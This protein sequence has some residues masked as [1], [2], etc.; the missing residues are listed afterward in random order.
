MRPID[1]DALKEKIDDIWNG[2]P[3][4]SLGA[5]LLAMIDSAP[6]IEPKAKVIAQVTFDEDKLREI[7]H[8]AV[9]RIKEEYDIVDGWIPCSE[10]LPEETGRY[11]CTVGAPYRNPRE[12]Y[13][14]PQEWAD[15]S[16]NATWRSIDGSYVFD[17]F[18]E[19]WMPR[20][21]EHTSELQSRI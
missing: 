2:R 15:K 16:N 1:A 21:E 5:R 8:E 4:S 17:W 7:V 11:L 3:L 18:V 6:T 13:Y 20:S 10:R 19:A 9:E 12:M 14:A